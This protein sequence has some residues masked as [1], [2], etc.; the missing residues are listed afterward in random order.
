M[1]MVSSWC[2]DRLSGIHLGSLVVLSTAHHLSILDDRE[3]QRHVGAMICS[4][5]NFFYNLQCFKTQESTLVFLLS[6]LNYCNWTC[7]QACYV[8]RCAGLRCPRRA[9]DGF[10]NVFFGGPETAKDSWHSDKKGSVFLMVLL[11]FNRCAVIFII[12]WSIFAIVQLLLYPGLMMVEC[13]WLLLPQ[14]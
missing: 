8:G 5:T 6:I 13:Y 2:I 1:R 3:G 12:V 11:W 10:A 7:A 9:M 4:W 14:R